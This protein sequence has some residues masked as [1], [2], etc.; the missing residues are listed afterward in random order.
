MLLRIWKDPVWSKVISVG[1]IAL[2]GLIYS[3]IKDN[4]KNISLLDRL[5]NFIN[6]QLPLW[7]FFVGLL[8]LLLL[9]VILKAINRNQ[10]KNKQKEHIPML[11]SIMIK[12]FLKK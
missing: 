3:W 8:F 4:N 10:K 11:K 7:L 5:H 12:S 9:P 6:I 1:I 2:A